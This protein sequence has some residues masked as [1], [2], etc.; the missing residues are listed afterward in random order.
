MPQNNEHRLFLQDV[1]ACR[2]ETN[3]AF[4]GFQR[5]QRRGADGMSPRNHLE[6]LM[7]HGQKV[8][9]A[10]GRMIG[11]LTDLPFGIDR[12]KVDP[13][14]QECEQ[15][16]GLMALE[17]RIAKE[18]CEMDTANARETMARIAAL[19][20]Q[21]LDWRESTGPV[22]TDRQR[23]AIL[24]DLARNT[25]DERHGAYD[26]AVR[27]T[28]GSTDWRGGA[29]GVAVGSAIIA[30]RAL[31]SVLDFVVAPV[32]ALGEALYRV[33]EFT[34]GKVGLWAGLRL[35]AG[36]PTVLTNWI[37]G[38]MVFCNLAG[39]CLR[40]RAVLKVIVCLYLAGLVMKLLGIIPPD[41]A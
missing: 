30:G 34:P 15:Q 27:D 1:Q 28:A 39:R 10:H 41:P 17:L 9:D 18:L 6:I 2:R 24:G 4:A 14:A 26:P 31:W 5:E 35:G 11:L 22:L 37:G 38:T 32:A 3:E 33:G 21:V 19:E 20:Q 29:G 25:G 13:V 16:S 7:S 12:D 36:R 40:H 8:A 23:D